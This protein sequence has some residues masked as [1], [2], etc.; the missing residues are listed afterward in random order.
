MEWRSI[1]K[2]LEGQGWQIRETSKGFLCYPPDPTR[3]LVLVHRQP[4]EQALKK[5]L[6]DLKRQGFQW[7]PG[8]ETTR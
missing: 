3:S 1:R 8:E 7:P 6:S 4:T 5:T 2:E